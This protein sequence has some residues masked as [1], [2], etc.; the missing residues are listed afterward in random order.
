MLFMICYMLD[1]VSS[2]ELS[3]LW[4]CCVSSLGWMIMFM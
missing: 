2:C 3:V 1:V 4:C